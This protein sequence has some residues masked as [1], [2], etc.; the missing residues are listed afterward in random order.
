MIIRHVAFTN[1]GVYGGRN[2]FELIP[3]TDEQF[4]RPIVLFSGK[5]GS[6]KTTFVE[7]IRLCLHGSLALGDRLSRSDYEE[8]LLR[9]IHRPFQEGVT[10][11]DSASIEMEF[12]F[13]RSGERHTYRVERSWHRT[14]KSVSENLSITEDGKPPQGDCML[15][16]GQKRGGTSKSPQAVEEGGGHRLW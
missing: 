7:G 13:V 5:N 2:E 8:H 9:K 12:E 15:C 6:G 3:R 11:P 14:K 10:P 4:S 1:F 16:T